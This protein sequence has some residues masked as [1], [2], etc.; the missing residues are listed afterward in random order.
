MHSLMNPIAKW[1]AEL[2]FSLLVLC[3]LVLWILLV[4]L[5]PPLSLI[6]LRRPRPETVRLRWPVLAL[7]ILSC[8]YV[9]SGC[10]TAPLPGP[11]SPRVPAALLVPPQEPIPLVPRAAASASKT[12]GPTTP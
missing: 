4:L 2:V 11:T 8:L 7:L 1:L 5:W 3:R 12:P 6:G 10:G 9:L